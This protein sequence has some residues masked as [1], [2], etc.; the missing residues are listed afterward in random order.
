MFKTAKQLMEFLELLESQGHDLNKI[1]IDIGGDKTAP[2]GCV[3]I[4]SATS[5]L[6]LVRKGE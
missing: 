1:T 3:C 2:L 6:T 5:I 4:D